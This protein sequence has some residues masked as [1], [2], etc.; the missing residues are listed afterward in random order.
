MRKVL[1]TLGGLLVFGGLIASA[2]A[3]RI[4]RSHARAEMKALLNAPPKVLTAQSKL[5]PPQEEFSLPGTVLAAQT[6]D[7]FA[8]SDGYVKKIEVDI[9]AKVKAGQLLATLVAPEINDDINRLRG[10]VEE[11]EKNLALTRSL[12]DRVFRAAQQGVASAQEVE[13]ARAR[14]NTAQA[15]QNTARSQF[16]RLSVFKDYLRVTAPFDGIVTKRYVDTGAL[17]SNGQTQLF[18][19]A[20]I[21]MLKVYV[22]V[23]Q[24]Y[25]S[26]VREGMQ[27]SVTAR[28]NATLRVDAN[29]IR[30][31]GALDATTH[32]LRVDARFPFTPILP[33]GAFVY[34]AFKVEQA[35]RAVR[36]PARALIIRSQGTQVVTV[37]A[38]QRARFVHVEVARDLGNEVEIA[39]GLSPGE[40]V[41]LS[42][43]DSVQD[44]QTVTL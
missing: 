16:K 30:T 40:T 42:P 28:D 33:P 27:V 12:A 6:V 38:Q 4:E 5:A 29:V 35:H 41:I 11:S 25:A 1:L 32:T 17:V 14:L 9:G 23:P 2:V 3:T 43:P 39:Q 18:Q 13:D 44:G 8:R 21:G 20:E 15:A 22:D 10:Q 26:D 37:D 19:V 34:V 31:S 24:S 36:I 7:L